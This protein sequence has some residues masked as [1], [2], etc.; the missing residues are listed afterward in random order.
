[1]PAPSSTS[2]ASQLIATT[3]RLAG[4]GTDLGAASVD[5]L[6]AAGSD[7]YLWRDEEFGL[8]GRGVAARIDL[9]GGLDDDAVDTVAGTLAAIQRDGEL[10]GLGTGPVALGALPFARD[11]PGTLVVPK[12]LVGRHEG[13]AWVTTVA[14][15]GDG[16]ATGRLAE[17]MAA[18]ALGAFPTHLPSPPHGRAPSQFTLTSVMDHDA[19]SQMVAGAIARVQDG[20]LGKVVLSRQVEVTANRPFVIPDVLSRLLALYPTCMIFRIGGFIGAS[21]ELLI[22]RRGDR[23]ASHPLAGTIGRS[24]DLA[25]DEAL[26]SGLLAS[27]KQRREHAYVIEGLRSSLAPVCTDL[28]VP[29]KPTV[30]ELRNVCHLATRLTGV[31]SARAATKG[32]AEAGGAP[33]SWA[34]GTAHPGLRVPDAL[35]L[36]SRVHPT[37]AVGGSPTDAAV[38]CIGE[39]E[40]YDRGLYAGPVGWMDARGDGSWAIGL[41]SATVDGDRA[42][43]Y[44]GVGLV[45]GSRPGSELEETQ[46]KLQALLAAMV[47]P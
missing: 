13:Q 46:L 32:E 38:A 14:G 33:A 27:P 7:G 1:M 18:D 42:T 5:L 45:A 9:P 16:P 35:Q 34:D 31:L 8:A 4:H 47:R 11:V 37:A 23:V 24:G 41:R 2:Q 26:I 17:R 12:V 30:L 39:I 40:G 21:P 36:V 25:T 6:A 10:T 19:W 28:D 43:L 20:G 15:P 3:T 44:A 29:D 22:E